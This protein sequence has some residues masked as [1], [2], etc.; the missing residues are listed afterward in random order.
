M[1]QDREAVVTPLLTKSIT[2]KWVNTRDE[3]LLCKELTM[4]NEYVYAHVSIIKWHFRHTQPRTTNPRF[5]NMYQ[6]CHVINIMSISQGLCLQCS[7]E[8]YGVY[9]VCCCHILV[10]CDGKV[11]IDMI[12]FIFWRKYHLF[13]LRRNYG[14]ATR[15]FNK[16]AL[17]ELQGPRV[18]LLLSSD[19]SSYSF[20]W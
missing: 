4:V 7:F 1:K 9:G 14:K 20:F 5:K 19:L 8:H 12:H 3:A 11:K 18:S 16:W 6:R 17:S 2:S 10:I 15:F 13:K